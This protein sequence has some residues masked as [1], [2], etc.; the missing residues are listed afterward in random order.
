MH[1]PSSD[2]IYFLYVYAVFTRS[3]EKSGKLE[4]KER[5]KARIRGKEKN[6]GNKGH[7][8]VVGAAG[9]FY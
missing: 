2:L 7:F 4:K 8:F 1:F 9:S 5:E 3:I 6:N